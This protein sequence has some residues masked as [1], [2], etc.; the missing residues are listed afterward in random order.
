MSVLYPLQTS[1][2]GRPIHPDQLPALFARRATDSHKGNFGSVGIIGGAAGMTGAALLA[3]RAALQLGAGKVLLGFVQDPPPLACDPLQPELML[4]TAQ[5]L[6]EGQWGITA[7]VAGCG[8]G[9]DVIAT[10]A[11]STLFQSRA[12]TPLVLDAD[13][14]NLLARGEIQ[15]NWGVG[16]VVLTPHPAEAGRL[17]GQE[18]DQVQADRPAAARALARRY[19]AWVILKGAGTLICRPSGD[20]QINTRGNPGLASAGTGDVLAGMLGALIA[21]GI[22][23]EQAVTGAVWLHGAAADALVARGVGPIG[24]CANELISAARALRNRH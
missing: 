12:A 8:I 7:W 11:L 13:G 20:C 6:L 19:D 22:P 1:P 4:R 24:L 21:Q 9:T 3:G 2:S 10:Q 16:P 5:A 18:S 23:L 17:L 15:P 14:L